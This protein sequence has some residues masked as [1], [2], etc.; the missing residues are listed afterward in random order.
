MTKPAHASL[1]QQGVHAGNFS[2]LQNDVV[3][4]FVTKIS[5]E[6]FKSLGRYGKANGIDVLFNP[7]FK[8]SGVS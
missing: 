3:C 8:L 2:S 1:F 4:H 7:V 6:I 5:E